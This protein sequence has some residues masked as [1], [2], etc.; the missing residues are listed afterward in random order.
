MIF[1]ST[2]LHFQ[3][4]KQIDTTSVDFYLF[5]ISTPADLP[6]SVKTLAGSASKSVV[7]YKHL[8]YLAY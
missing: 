1:Y 5:I 2:K 8:N 7:L 6:F 3:N 4:Y